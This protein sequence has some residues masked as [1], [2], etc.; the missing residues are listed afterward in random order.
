[1][2]QF[3]LLCQLNLLNVEDSHS[4]GKDFIAAKISPMNV[5]MNSMRRSHR[6]SRF[7][8]SFCTEGEKSIYK[9]K[10]NFDM[11]SKRI[12]LVE[13]RVDW[14]EKLTIYNG[15]TLDE[16][17]KCYR[18]KSKDYIQALAV[19]NCLTRL[20]V[21]PKFSLQRR[22]LSMGLTV[23]RNFVATLSLATSLLATGTIKFKLGALAK[24]I[25]FHKKPLALRERLFA[26]F[27]TLLL[28]VFSTVPLRRCSC[29]LPR[30]S[31][32]SR[33][34][35]SF[36]SFSSRRG[37]VSSIWRRFRAGFMATRRWRV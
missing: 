34:L 10:V 22:S 26:V 4:I 6:R 18:L 2:R 16:I 31:N 20:A 5:I 7:I 9:N 1:M 29:R 15:M 25:S 13:E 14:S 17:V 30:R 8:L 19:L 21:L 23:K 12:D 27:L 37:C 3:I 36:C 28:C 35:C 11:K 32:A 33:H 24:T